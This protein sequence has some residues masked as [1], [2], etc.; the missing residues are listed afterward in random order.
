MRAGWWFV[1]GVA[2]CSGDKD[3][4]GSTTGA[5]EIPCQYSTATSGGLCQANVYCDSGEFAVYCGEQEDGTFACDC[6]AAADDPPSFDSDDFCAV[7]GE[8]RVCQAIERCTNWAL[9]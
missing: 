8:E 2:A 5:C 4:G 6:G 3:D 9:P 7:D 1:V